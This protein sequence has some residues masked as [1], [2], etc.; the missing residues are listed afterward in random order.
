MRTLSPSGLRVPPPALLPRG[1]RR[2]IGFWSARRRLSN[3]RSSNDL[4]AIGPR[5]WSIRAAVSNTSAQIGDN[6][7]AGLL[8]GPPC[9][10][11]RQADDRLAKICRDH[12]GHDGPIRSL[13]LGSASAPHVQ[14]KPVPS[15]K[16][17]HPPTKPPEG[18]T[19]LRSASQIGAAHCQSIALKISPASGCSPANS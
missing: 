14:H 15:A 13:T 7:T 19:G 10:T 9:P 1:I 16:W 8:P 18:A 17:K 11:H 5:C 12:W 6:Q 2:V 3:R 4:A